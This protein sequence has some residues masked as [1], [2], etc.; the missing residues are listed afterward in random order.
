MNSNTSPPKMNSAQAKLFWKS[1]TPQQRADFNKMMARLQ[2]GE[3][4][5]TKITVDDNEQIQR[6]IL[7]PKDKPSKPI[8]PFGKHFHIE[9]KSKDT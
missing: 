5:L 4:M 2:K 8:A 7:E 3:L 6:I 9:D 1:L